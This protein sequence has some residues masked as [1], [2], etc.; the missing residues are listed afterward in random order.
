MQ[1]VSRANCYCSFVYALPATSACVRWAFTCTAL[2]HSLILFL[3]PSP[4]LSFSLSSPSASLCR[5]APSWYLHPTVVTVPF[6]TSG[7]SAASSTLLGGRDSEASSGY[8][9]GTTTAP[10][11]Q[12][13]LP[14][15]VGLRCPRRMPVGQRQRPPPTAADELLCPKQIKTA[16]DPN[17]SLCWNA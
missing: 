4:Y 14:P 10:A 6:T 16:F 17:G 11:S 2:A 8:L 5:I 12:H 1:Q 9:D 3:S 13:S 7:G 15:T